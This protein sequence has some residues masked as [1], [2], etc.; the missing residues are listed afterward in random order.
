M[1]DVVNNFHRQV[2]PK[3][4]GNKLTQLTAFATLSSDVHVHLGKQTVWAESSQ[5]GAGA[6]AT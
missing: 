5:S 3:L 6:F 1:V 4:E 2:D